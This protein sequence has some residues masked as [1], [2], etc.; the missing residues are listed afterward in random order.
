VTQNTPELL[1]GK[2]GIISL[3]SYL[4]GPNFTFAGL[5]GR[6]LGA[7]TNTTPFI[8]PHEAIANLDIRLVI[9]QRFREVI[10]MVRNHFDKHGFTD[11]KINVNS[12][13]SHTLIPV[14]DP[15]V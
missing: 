1:G 6:F 5:R 8:F 15:V 7:G 2:E 12:A 9:E 10:Q 3:V 11:V 4:Y 13:Y 14:T